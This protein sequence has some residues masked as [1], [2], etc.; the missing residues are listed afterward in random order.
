[1]TKYFPDLSPLY[2]LHRALGHT[3]LGQ[4]T[5]AL[6]YTGA[7]LTWTWKAKN[8]MPLVA[9]LAC[10]ALLQRQQKTKTLGTT[11]GPTIKANTNLATNCLPYTDFLSLAAQ[12]NYSPTKLTLAIGYTGNAHQY[13]RKKGYL[14]PYATIQLQSLL[15]SQPKPTAPTPR[16][17]ETHTRVPYSEFHRLAKL[18]GY[19]AWE[20]GNHLGYGFT[21]VEYWSHSGHL[22]LRASDKF[23]SWLTITSRPAK[24][25]P[26]QTIVAGIG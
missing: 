4:T 5:A 10:E 13:W 12:H 20:L 26:G 19:S 3:N 9:V 15:S 11:S 22:S 6:G 25:I 14:S 2:T 21:S 24:L 8:R 23:Y 18:N 1:M 17:N 16:H 7:N